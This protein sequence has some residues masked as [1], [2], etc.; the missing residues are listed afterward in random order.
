MLSKIGHLE[1]DRKRSNIVIFGLE[2]KGKERYDDSLEVA[3]KV[4]EEN[5]RLEILASNNDHIESL[6]EEEASR[7]YL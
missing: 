6:Q 1:G 5:V 3:K 7:L 2:E 4:L